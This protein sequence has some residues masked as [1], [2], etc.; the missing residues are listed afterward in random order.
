MTTRTFS[1]KTAGGSPGAEAAEWAGGG[2]LRAMAAGLW[3]AGL[4]LGGG[5]ACG[6]RSGMPR[7]DGS[8]GASSGGGTSGGASSTR[9]TTGTSTSTT[10]TSTSTSTTST[11]TSG[12]YDPNP[13]TGTGTGTGTGGGMAPYDGPY[14]PCSTD[15]D[16]PST[17]NENFQTC[18]RAVCKVT[19]LGSVCVPVWAWCAP[20]FGWEYSCPYPPSSPLPDCSE[21]DKSHPAYEGCASPSSTNVDVECW[22]DS[23]TD[24]D[25]D[26]T[27]GCNPPSTPCPEGMVCDTTE[28]NAICV[29]P[30]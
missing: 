2:G 13:G 11:S 5:A 7:G 25:P 15:E 17:Y 28:V 21:A 20:E 6:V 22:D 18:L 8:G 19:M 1:R 16:C 3:V 27:L 9:G 14:R 4:L 26:C 30:S 29:W 24:I 23:P 12:C 10:S